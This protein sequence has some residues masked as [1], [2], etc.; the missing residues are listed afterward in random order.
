MSRNP[1]Q[2]RP[3]RHESGTGR[4]VNRV[5]RRPSPPEPRPS[6]AAVDVGS[7][8]SPSGSSAVRSPVLTA[9]VLTA[10]Q[11]REPSRRRG[12]DLLAEAQAPGPPRAQDAV[13][14]RMATTRRVAFG[15]GEHVAAQRRKQ[16]AT[17]RAAV[18]AR[19]AIRGRAHYVPAGVAEVVGHEGSVYQSASRLRGDWTRRGRAGTILEPFESTSGFG[20]VHD[21]RPLGKPG[22]GPL[23][24]P[25]RPALR[26]PTFP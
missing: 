26:R 22:V 23:A 3:T 20:D 17:Q 13:G 4:A 25:P 19:L 10:A 8:V 14:V 15:E 2:S 16:P 12:I 7:P 11:S 1:C 6:P 24:K 21:E 18:G 5:P 9:L